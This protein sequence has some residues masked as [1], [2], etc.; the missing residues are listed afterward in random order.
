MLECLL[1]LYVILL[2]IFP[3]PG[4]VLT[5]A[6]YTGF[7]LYKKFL[8]FRHQP[9]AG[10]RVFWLTLFCGTV[11]F[12]L[13]LLLG[14][15][16]A[17]G[18]YFLITDFLFIFVFNFLFCANISLRWFDY[19]HQVFRRWVYRWQGRTPS[20]N[21][22]S[23]DRVFVM[24]FGLRKFSGWGFGLIP[25]W[26]DAGD[27][28]L[29]QD[30][31]KFEGTYVSL[32]LSPALMKQVDPVSSERIRFSTHR[33]LTPQP[34]DGYWLILRDGF[35]PFK[36]RPRRNRVLERLIPPGSPVPAEA[37]STPLPSPGMPRG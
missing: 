20:R 26:M 21:T 23:A 14:L 29:G 28:D 25:F 9:E 31:V 22:A 11:N 1:V 5:L 2:F 36:S 7:V 24:L 19:T 10:R 34:A 35:Y 15:L 13:S 3:V 30:P 12:V 18:V 17:L 27:L 6:G 33:P 32:T 37:V 4:L 8:L 16:L